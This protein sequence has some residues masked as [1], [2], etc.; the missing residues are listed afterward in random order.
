MTKPLKMAKKI[1]MRNSQFP[2]HPFFSLF[3]LFFFVISAFY[4]VMKNVGVATCGFLAYLCICKT[5]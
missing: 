3:S 5:Y 1:L 2:L 4:F